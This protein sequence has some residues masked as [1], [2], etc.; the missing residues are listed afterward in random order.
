MRR[1]YS[2]EKR[3]QLVALVTTEGA[4]ILE[5][6]HQPGVRPSTAYYWIR[7]AA[8]ASWSITL[9]RRPARLRSSRLRSR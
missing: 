8:K 2:A 9:A 7:Q 5:A 1:R 6:A 3:S 4:P